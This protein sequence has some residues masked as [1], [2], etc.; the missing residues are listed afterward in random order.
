MNG[1]ILTPDFA[2]FFFLFLFLMQAGIIAKLLFRGRQE[3]VWR[4]LC[5][6]RYLMAYAVSYYKAMAYL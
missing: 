4:M 2:V 5:Y 1:I 3:K 6:V